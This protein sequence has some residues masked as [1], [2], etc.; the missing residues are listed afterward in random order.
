[1]NMKKICAAAIFL[2]CFVQT[3]EAKMTPE[4]HALYQQACSY[5]YKNDYDTAISTMQKALAINGED[6]MLY[7]KIAGLYADI[8]RYEEA[9]GAY[10]KA[11]K[12]RPNDAFIYISM[13]NILQTI[14]DYENA[15]NS[16]LQA[17]KIY[18]EYKYNYL[19][20]ANV[21]YL[22]KNYKDAVENYNIFLSAYP[23]H[24]EASESLAEIYYISGEPEKACEIYSNIYKKYPSAF[25]EYKKYGL[26]LFDTKQ[27]DA[28]VK[29]LEK[30]LAE[31][32]NDEALWAKSALAYQNIK[33]NEKSLKC[34]IKV[35]EL[36]PELTMLRFD[37]ANLLG[38]IGKETEAVEQYKLYIA[39]YPEDADAYRNLGLMYKKLCNEDLAMFNF[40]KAYSLNSSDNET[41]KELGLCY[42]K[43]Q[44]Y[45][46]ALKYY[47]LALKSEPENTEL[48]TNKALA[49][50][51]TDN[52]LA[53][54]EIY[55]T[56]LE[57]QS[58]E[59]LKR[60]LT[61]AEISYGY[62]LL[63]K[64][65][66][67]QAILY[68][69][70]A[71]ELN[72]KESSAYYGLALANEKF[73]STNAAVENYKK[74]LSLEPENKTYQSALNR[75]LAVD[76]KTES[77]LTREELIDKG[78]KAYGKQQ[79]NEAIE[80]Y[81]KALVI[82]PEDSATMLKTA[83]IYKLT[84]NNNMAL[85]FYDKALVCEPENTDAYFNKGLIYA[86]Q[87]NYDECIKCFEKV[88]EL[89]PDY[90]YAYYSMGLAYE[91]KDDIDKA[92]E[93]YY[94]YIGLETDQVMIDMVNRKIKQ[95]EK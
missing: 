58:D 39:A 20:I 69:E 47:D 89:S 77:A 60:N 5:E 88:L 52:Y 26:A 67:G 8:G 19:N 15:Y 94:L 46:K 55:K 85:S 43:K 9:L 29:M 90:P 81:T 28:S 84:G 86:S 56:L 51:A 79:Y 76:T 23:E 38:N 83:N 49:L 54:I 91:Q 44:D 3:A 66:Y 92:L 17:Q 41:K 53:A 30:A 64:K 35:F 11:V 50:H 61:S 59:R 57:K 87:K 31:D 68:F 95:L 7:T 40:E 25:K 37:Y 48:L 82:N 63:D 65:D 10:K 24:H 32:E 62:S 14:G 93:Y 33:E 78:D 27:Y 42:H 80:C 21:E 74:A 45:V 18:P 13:G 34:F 71:I 2:L 22:T 6:A 72:E 1:M 4:A 36:N 73:G 12:I 16:F 75:V 70:D